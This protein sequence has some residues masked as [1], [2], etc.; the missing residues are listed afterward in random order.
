MIWLEVLVEGDSDL[1]VINEVLVRKFNLIEGEQFR[2]HPHKGK[3]NLP[4]NPLSRPNPKHQGLL[5]QLPAKLRGFSKSL[6]SDS[7]VVV[8]IDA[9]NHNPD[10]LLKELSSMLS[11]LP[12]KPNVLFRLAIEEIESWFIADIAAL[13]LAYPNQIKARFLTNIQPDSIVG[14]C[15]KLAQSLGIDST[16]IAGP[17][18]FAWAKQIAPHL[19]LD[20]PTSPSFKKLIDGIANLLISK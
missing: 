3:G 4:L 8:L 6:P 17:T 10:V 12:T 20:S 15:E 18:K 2:I 14:A 11:A 7:W 5:D 16:M 13:K 1:P 9:D 19:N